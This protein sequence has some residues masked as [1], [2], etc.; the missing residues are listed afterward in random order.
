MSLSCIVIE[1]KRKNYASTLY[2]LSI[3][4]YSDS[5]FFFP[6]MYYIDMSN[7]SQMKLFGPKEN[8]FHNLKGSDSLNLRHAD[9]KKLNHVIVSKVLL[10][11]HHHM[12]LISP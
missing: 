11:D 2:K 10:C 6:N 9:I 1:I 4:K 7:K 5:L 3:H 12:I 8:Y